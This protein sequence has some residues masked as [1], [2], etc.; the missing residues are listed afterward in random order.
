MY[1]HWSGDH[2]YTT[3]L[4]EFSHLM[5]IGWT[6]EGVGWYSADSKDGVPL[7]RLFNPYAQVGSH[8]YTTSASERDELASIGWRA[9]G[10]GW[11]GLK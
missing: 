7:Y 3:E 8:L 1:N 9:E 6:G 4:S 10:I 11:Y 2:H 5:S